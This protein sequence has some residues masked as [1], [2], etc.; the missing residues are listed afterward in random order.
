MAKRKKNQRRVEREIDLNTNQ[1]YTLQSTYL[2]L[3]AFNT[4]LMALAIDTSKLEA[5][6]EPSEVSNLLVIST[7]MSARALQMPLK[8]TRQIFGNARG[9]LGDTM[10]FKDACDAIDEFLDYIEAEADGYAVK[11][12]E[13]LQP[14]LAA[15]QEELEP[16]I[17]AIANPV[18]KFV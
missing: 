12:P 7:T 17:E 16:V 3:A 14:S 18:T 6:D 8:E 2:Q 13:E 4:T 11:F 1:L 15:A 5:D 10:V 9:F